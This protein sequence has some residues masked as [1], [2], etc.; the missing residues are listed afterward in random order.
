MHVQLN[1]CAEIS[2]RLANVN[3][4][5]AISTEFQRYKRNKSLVVG[6]IGDLEK[7]VTQRFLIDIIGNMHCKE[8]RYIIF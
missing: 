4:P 3:W 5:L 1:R 2:V 8:E 6:A 7:F